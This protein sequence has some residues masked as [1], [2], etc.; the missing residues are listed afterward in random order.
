MTVILLET[1]VSQRSDVRDETRYN[2]YGAPPLFPTVRSGV[3]GPT[4]SKVRLSARFLLFIPPMFLI[5]LI[6][7]DL[8]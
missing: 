1:E 3:L 5:T 7:I 8:E 2:R 4:D 6:Q